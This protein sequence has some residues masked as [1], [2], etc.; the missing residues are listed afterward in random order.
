MHTSKFV[1]GSRVIFGSALAAGILLFPSPSSA[2]LPGPLPP[3]RKPPN[4]VPLTPVEQLGKD[5]LYDSTL[6]DPPGYSCFTCHVPQT[7]FASTSVSE[8][9]AILGIMPGVIPGRISKRE[10]QTYS[11]TTVRPI[12]PYFNATVGCLSGQLLGR[13]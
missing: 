9:N 5:I 6:S 13:S 8:V 3:P 10:P 2:Q 1:V 11:M 12:G 7:G 4:I